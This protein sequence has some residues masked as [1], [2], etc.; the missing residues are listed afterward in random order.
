MRRAGCVCRA[1]RR[2]PTATPKWESKL[3]KLRRPATTRATRAVTAVIE[4]AT[5]ATEETVEVIEVVI[6]AHAIVVPV[7]NIRA[8]KPGTPASCRRVPNSAQ[9]CLIGSQNR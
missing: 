8:T 3:K 7:A 1:E 9:A 5:V 2:W 6:A 4:E